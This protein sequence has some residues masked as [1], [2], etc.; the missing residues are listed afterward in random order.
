MQILSENVT[1]ISELKK[2]PSAVK[3]NIDTCVLSHNKPVYY[4]VNPLRYAQ[5]LRAEKELNDIS[6]K[7]RGE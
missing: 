5:L 6:K 4:T 7:L 2:N 1:C 3:S